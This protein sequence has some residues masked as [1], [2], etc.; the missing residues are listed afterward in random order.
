[1]DLFSDSWFGGTTGKAKNPYAG[2]LDYH[3]PHTLSPQEFML[4]KKEFMIEDWC[5]MSDLA[6]YDRW[7]SSFGKVDFHLK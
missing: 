2:F 7:K 4:G 3:A 5:A 6:T 1:M